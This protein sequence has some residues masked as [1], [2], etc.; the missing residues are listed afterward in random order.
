MNDRRFL[1]ILNSVAAEMGTDLL[2]PPGEMSEAEVVAAWARFLQ[3]CL[4][5]GISVGDPRWRALEVRTTA[6]RPRFHLP[7][8]G[9]GPD[10][11][12]AGDFSVGLALLM[13]MLGRTDDRD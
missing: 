5:R 3:A 12:D 9:G 11:G 6:G 10:R 4:G 13:S 7:E 8:G 2:S 1:A